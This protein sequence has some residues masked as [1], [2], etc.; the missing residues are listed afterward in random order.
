M[1]IDENAPA[2][3]EGEIQ[4]EASPE[5]VWSV[6]SDIDDWPTW[7]SDIK[8]AKLD[9]PV[10]VGSTFRWKSGPASLTSTLRSVDPPREIGWTGTTMSIKA[11][12]VFTLRP[13]DGRTLVRSEE[14]WEGLVASMFKSYSRKTLSKGI[15]TILANL[16]REA[17]RPAT[18]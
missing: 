17:E 9:G 10:E 7:N 3:A 5:V 12:H 13:Q 14:S 6:L 4:V 16:K 18:A 1:E 15:Q 11:V 2:T 8:M